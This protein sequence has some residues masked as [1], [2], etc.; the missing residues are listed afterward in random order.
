MLDLALDVGPQRAAADGEFDGDR[1]ESVGADRD[2]GDHAQGDDVGAEL[3]VDHRGQDLTDLVDGG[4]FGGGS[5][6][7]GH[8]PDFTGPG[9]VI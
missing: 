3:G 9:R 4:R 1:H 5:P 8:G 6:L 7:G 2:V